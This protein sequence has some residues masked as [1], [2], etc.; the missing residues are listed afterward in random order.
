M[1]IRALAAIALLAGSTTTTVFA[2]PL[3]PTGKWVADFAENKCLLSRSYGS[4]AKPLILTFE[5]L[6]MDDG[7]EIH[8]FKRGG[9]Q[10]LRGG[11]AKVDFGTNAPADI[12]FGAFLTTDNFRRVDIDFPGDSYLAA[13]TTER[14][15]V[16]ASGEINE[17]F[18]LPNFAAALGVL[19]DCVVDLGEHWGISAQDQSRIGN[20]AKPVQSL[21]AYFSGEDYPYEALKNGA[22][23]R[24]DVRVGIDE[25]GAPTD[26]VIM[27]PSGN[28]ALDRVTCRVLLRRAHFHPATDI[29]GRPMKSVI[30]TGV[31]WV[32]VGG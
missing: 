6:P 30:V 16:S 20:P 19:H 8:I 10:D 5:Q 17:T 9:R 26:C 1:F 18:A 3:Q 7:I 2:S 21:G 28:E 14:L 13:K 29:S 24:T 11:Q 27:R 23:G 22:T 15:S 4:D 12:R 25:L 32:L 31:N